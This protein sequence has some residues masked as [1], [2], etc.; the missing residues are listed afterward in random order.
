MSVCLHVYLSARISQK[1]H[2]QTSRNVSLS[3]AVAESSSDNNA[4]RYVFPVLWM[5][6]YF[7]TLW[8]NR[9]DDVMFGR[10]RQV[11]RSRGRSLLSSVALLCRRLA[12]FTI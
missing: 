8:Q 9:S 7:Y 12:C 5:T 1:P 11:A 3:V 10:F 6:S 4:K 2:V